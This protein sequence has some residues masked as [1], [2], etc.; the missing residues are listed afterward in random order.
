M[1]TVDTWLV[2]GCA[3]VNEDKTSKAGEESIDRIEEH[4]I[5]GR[6]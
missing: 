3:E 2:G 6:G 4:T 1:Y 5:H